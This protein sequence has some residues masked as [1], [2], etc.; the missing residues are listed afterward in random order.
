MI[1]WFF[2]LYAL[3]VYAYTG[4]T[5]ISYDRG[6]VIAMLGFPELVLDCLFVF[7]IAVLFER[8]KKNENI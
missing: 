1:N 8:F 6:M 4:N 2:C 7:L 5:I 3:A